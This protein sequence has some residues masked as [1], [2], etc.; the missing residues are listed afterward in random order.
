MKAERIFA[1]F[2]KGVLILLAAGAILATLSGGWGIPALKS[3]HDFGYLLD[4]PAKPGMHIQGS[5]LYTYD[6]FASEETYTQRSDGTRSMGKTSGFYYAIPSYDGVIG[7]R[8][9]ADDYSD[10]EDLLDETITYLT[11]GTEH[12]TSVWVDGRIGKMDKSTRGLF[13]EYLLDMG[14][15]RG[16]IADM[17]DPLIIE[18][19]ASMSQMKVMFLVG[20]GLI[21][22]AV[23]WFVINCIRYGRAA[24]RAQ[25]AYGTAGTSYGQADAAYSTAGT[26]YGQA[27]GYGMQPGY[28][29][30]GGYGTQAGA[31][32]GI[33]AAGRKLAEAVPNKRKIWLTAVIRS[34]VVA[35]V[36]LACGGGI[37]GLSGYAS[38]LSGILFLIIMFVVIAGGTGLYTLRH[39]TERMEFCEYGICWKG[40]FYSFTDLGNISWR[41][42]SQAGFFSRDKIDTARGSFD[43]TYLDRPRKAYNQ[44]YMDQ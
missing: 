3:P 5:V 9:S 11:D 1:C 7:L 2:S 40:R 38:D 15:T 13:E 33:P 8:V 20:I 29:Q 32:A 14:F 42:I 22:L 31:N 44:A 23:V 34:L 41:S 27:G 37:S 25:A 39:L 28:G 19:P 36:F 6:C 4:N 35:L 10:M 16:E 18:C 17:G 30:A 21:L 26:G 12:V 43:V 24:K